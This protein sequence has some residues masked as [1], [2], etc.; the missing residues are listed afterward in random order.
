[1]SSSI[2]Q[3][4]MNMLNTNSPLFPSSRNN[5]QIEDLVSEETIN[6]T[7][8]EAEEEKIF[9]YDDY[10][11]YCEEYAVSQYTERPGKTVF[12]RVIDTS[13][14]IQSIRPIN[15]GKAINVYSHSEQSPI[16]ALVESE[17]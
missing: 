7:I 1:M 11:K 8:K 10:I 9:S 12:E 3:L 4:R 13:A 2:N 16:E 14:Q 6:N 17:G 15:I 5:V